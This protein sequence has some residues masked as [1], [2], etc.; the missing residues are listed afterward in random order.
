[1][2]RPH[3]RFD[4]RRQA[5]VTRAGGQLKILAKGPKNATT[6]A[7]AWDAF[8]AYLTKF[9]NPVEGSLLPRSRSVNPP[10]AMANG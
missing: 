8:Y 5:W 9:G 1:M 3:P 6:Q 2:R 7:A 10:T 4:E